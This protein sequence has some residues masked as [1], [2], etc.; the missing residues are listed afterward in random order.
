MTMTTATLQ[1]DAPLLRLTRF[2]VFALAAIFFSLAVGVSAVQFS[3][4]RDNILPAGSTL[5]GDYVAFYTAAHAAADGE[6]ATIYDRA[7][8]DERL[9][10]HGPPRERYGLTWQYPPTYFFMVLPLAFFGFAPG[11]ALWSGASAAAYFGA[12]RMAGFQG[13]FLFVI[14]AAPTTFHAVITGQNGF[15]TAALLI[16]AALYPD[17]RPIVAGLAAALLT[18]KPQLG[19]L[20]PIAFLAG[21]CWRAFFA[22]AIGTALLMLASAAAFGPESWTAFIESIVGISD[23]LAKGVMPLFK[24]VTPFANARFAGLPVE[25]SLIVHGIFAIAA[26]IGVG[27]VWRR[28]RDAEMRAAALCAGVFFVAPYGFYYE[29][30][31]LALPAALLARRAIENGWLRYEQIALG[32]IFILPMFLPGSSRKVGVSVGILVVALVAASVIRRINHDYPGTFWLKP[33]QP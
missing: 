29:L 18:V 24:M 7:Q 19:L 17:K 8:F 21:G 28:V 2:R 10:A 31:I 26:A 4:A 15:I 23:K 11:Y 13:L 1:S 6:A 12:M 16:V 27:V 9:H 14:L 3:G 5:G 20:L 22:A 30:I 25:A 33:R 32:A